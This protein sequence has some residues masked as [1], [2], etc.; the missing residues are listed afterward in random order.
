[1]KTAADLEH[2]RAGGFT[3]TDLAATLAAMTLLAFGFGNSIGKP[4]A[5]SQSAVCV[6]NLQQVI[7]AWQM[8][9]NE[10]NDRFPRIVS[11]GAALSPTPND[12]TGIS[13][14]TGWLDWNTASGNT[15]VLYLTD[16]RFSTLARYVGYR[17]DVFKCPADNY[18]GAAQR[19][20]GWKERVR[21]ISS[22]VAVGESEA[23]S[24]RWDPTFNHAR[25]T[26]DLTIPGPAETFVFLDEQADSMNDPAFYPPWNNGFVDL[27]ASYHEGS[28]SLAFADG[29]AENHPWKTRDALQ[30]VRFV[31]APLAGTPGNADVKWLQYHTP[32]RRE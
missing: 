30:L 18:L 25:K 24:G 32:R 6:N 10:N 22:N 7:R 15:N 23:E 28:G 31:Q 26:G 21:S 20:A 13:W 8:Y 5:A 29:H 2:G 19:K 11:G 1:M 9:A 12:P 17:K 14:A 27:P 3:R 16:S 4:K